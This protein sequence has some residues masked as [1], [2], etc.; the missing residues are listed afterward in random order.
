MTL[1]EWAQQ[2]RD[3]F[4]VPIMVER[5]ARLLNTLHSTGLVHRDLKPRQRA[6]SGRCTV[7][8]RKEGR[9]GTN[10]H[11]C[12]RVDPAGKARST[13]SHR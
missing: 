3:F 6:L 9:Q 12:A 5:L 13:R 2:E 4:D 1:T 8:R 7:G 11:R 10:I